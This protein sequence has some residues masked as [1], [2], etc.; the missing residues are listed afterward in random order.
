MDSTEQK[1]QYVASVIVDMLEE[2]PETSWEDVLLANT[3]ANWGLE[4]N[5]L[6]KAWDQARVTVA[7]AAQEEYL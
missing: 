5:E 7:E 2:N 4:P 6:R 1:T 3:R